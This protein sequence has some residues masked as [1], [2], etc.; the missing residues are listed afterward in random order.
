[1][2]H[3]FHGF[4]L[5]SHRKHRKHRNEFLPR[6]PRISRI[7]FCHTDL[8]DLT[9]SFGSQISQF[10]RPHSYLQVGESADLEAPAKRGTAIMQGAVNGLFQIKSKLS[11]TLNLIL[12]IR[13]ICEIRGQNICG[14]C[15]ICETFYLFRWYR[16]V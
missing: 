14:I 12:I 11:S 16:S 4:T 13:I 7:F 6:I 9:D 8:T 10:A 1:M 2:S 15:G 3:R 5:L